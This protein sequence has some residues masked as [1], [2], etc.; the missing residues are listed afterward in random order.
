MGQNRASQN[1]NRGNL[2][3]TRIAPM[4]NAQVAAFEEYLDE[5]M[6]LFLHGLPGTG[7]T[8]IAT[9]L[10]LHSV[11]VKRF[12]QK[13]VIVR[14]AVPTRN[15]GFLPGD[16]KKK[17]TIYEAPYVDA[18]TKLFDRGDAYQ[19]LKQKGVLEFVTTSY[20][21]GTNIDNAVVIVDEVQ[22]ME[23]QELRTIITRLGEN[24]RLILSGDVSQD[25]LSSERFSEYSGLRQMM[26]VLDQMDCLARV[27]FGVDDIVRSQLV[28]DFILAEDAVK[29]GRKPLTVA[30]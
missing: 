24:C 28:R 7:K 15:I 17:T 8:F 18:T 25:D 29:H 14:S 5:N 4:T 10:G 1:D 3:L 30:A 11:I 23:Y 26:K 21:R 9:Y 16:D 19:L 12:F 6:H 2:N 27:E 22:N 20:L 13:V